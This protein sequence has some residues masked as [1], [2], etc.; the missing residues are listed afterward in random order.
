MG[1]TSKITSLLHLSFA[2]LGTAVGNP[3]QGKTSGDF[4]VNPINHRQY[5][6]SLSTAHGK[7]KEN[8]K[9]MQSVPSAYWIDVKAKIKKTGGANDHRSLEG[10]LEDAANKTRPQLCVF[11]WYDLPNRDCKAHASNGE[12]CCKK[13]ADGKCDYMA[14][15][16]CEDGLREYKEEYVNPFVEVLQQYQNTVPIV[17]VVEPDS[18]PNLATN[19]AHP[20]CG[21]TATHAS[22]REGIKYALHQLT[23]KCPSVTVYLD[24]AHGGWLG[25]ENSM[26]AFMKVIKGMDLPQIRGFA[27]NVANYQPLGIQCPWCPDQGFRNGFCLNGQNTDHP[28]CHDPCGLASEWNFGNNELNYAAGLVAAADRMLGMDAHV[29]IDTGRNGVV[30]HRSDCSN[31]CNPRG[32]GAGVK[33]TTDVANSTFIDAYF[34]LKTP[35]ESD[36]CSETLPDG[37]KCPRFDRMCGSSDSLSSKVGEPRAPEAG[38]WFDHQVKQ[39]AELA[40][41]EQPRA[42]PSAG[43]TC[44][45]NGAGHRSGSGHHDGDDS[46]HGGHGN[47]H[48]SN[49]SHHSGGDGACA[50]VWNQCGG[51]QWQ[52]PTCCK[53]GCRCNREGQWYHQ[54]EPTIPGWHLCQKDDGI[55]FVDMAEQQDVRGSLGPRNYH[56]AVSVAL[57]CAAALSGVFGVSAIV[58]RSGLMRIVTGYLDTGSRPSGVLAMPAAELD[59]LEAPIE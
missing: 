18:L 50:D 41:F 11:M 13:L 23:Q 27:T 16:Q 44:S 30:D 26:E 56:P 5:E 14:G 17:I 39:L 54:C 24:A 59:L 48:S 47:H 35:G 58:S 49:G 43:K 46:H 4:Y 55:A 25:W 51:H 1:P 22:Y 45:S 52:G 33:S 10:I 7:V 32:S 8:L 21:G 37:S 29:I 3:F 6:A 53:S 57:V 42:D 34:W 12:I 31:W 20:H 38:H 36:G 19:V 28:C 9:E 15:G 2:A 40:N